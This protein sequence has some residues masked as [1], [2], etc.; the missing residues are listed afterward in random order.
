MTK[1]FFLI[2]M[3]LLWFGIFLNGVNVPPPL[4]SAPVFTPVATPA[5]E[6]AF[7]PGPVSS[8][9][10]FTDEAVQQID[11]DARVCRITSRKLKDLTGDY[12]AY[13]IECDNSAKTYLLAYRRD[14]RNPEIKRRILEIEDVVIC[15][16]CGGA[17]G[18]TSNWR[19]INSDG[20][21][22]LLVMRGNNY[23]FHGMV[24]LTRR[25]GKMT[26]LF[27]NC[28]LSLPG[29][30]QQLYKEIDWQDLDQDGILEILAT[31]TRWDYSQ[32]QLAPLRFIPAVARIYHV[33]PACRYQEVSTAY[34]EY[35]EPS[36]AQLE[37]P[38]AYDQME[39]SFRVQ[40]RVF[41]FFNGLL[42]CEVLNRR[43]ECWPR[44]WEGTDIQR[45]S[46]ET[47]IADS[48]FTAWLSKQR[49]HL[50]RQYDAGL[51]FIPEEK[52]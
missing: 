15:F 16:D 24:Y 6:P 42:A 44:F 10:G 18:M 1:A 43:A 35:Y 8:L 17:A 31:D 22:D 41:S 32:N 51:P 34:P 13:L 19:D 39:N 37:N 29:Q 30:P 25:A 33:Q 28:P 47:A 26:S 21:P 3:G 2:G 46:L 40:M 27:E 7:L 36:I 4:V 5:P 49:A 14:P 9:L 12:S 52:D 20:L 45:Y 38:P 11:R 48:D 50:K 23:V